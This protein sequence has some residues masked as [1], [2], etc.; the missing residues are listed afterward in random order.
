MEDLDSERK[1]EKRGI[2]RL[3]EREDVRKR[4]VEMED[5]KL[6]KLYLQSIQT[7]Q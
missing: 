5:S 3:I 7:F 4:K 1:R 6:N 2:G